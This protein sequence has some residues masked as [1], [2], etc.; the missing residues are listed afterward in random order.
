MKRQLNISRLVTIV[1]ALALAVIM[2]VGS[3]FSWY[4]RPQNTADVSNVKK[5]NYSVTGKVNAPRSVQ[6]KTYLGIE[7][8]GEF[9]YNDE[10]STSVAF[11]AGENIKY[12]KTDIDITNNGDAL[13]SLY[14]QGL[15]YSNLGEKFSIGIINPEKTLK[16]YSVT[17]ATGVYVKDFVCISDNVVIPTDMDDDGQ[18]FD[19]DLTVYWYIKF[20]NP[21]DKAD[22][23]ELNLGKMH[24]VYN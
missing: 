1:S 7:D 13:V 17:G 20:D 21:N 24:L 3:T 12:F 16:K 10:V 19:S 15:T 22:I 2:A 6:M 4:N 18:E 9:T 11:S 14:L 5:L 8:K 23:R